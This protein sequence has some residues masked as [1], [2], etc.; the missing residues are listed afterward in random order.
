MAPELRITKFCLERAHQELERKRDT[1]QKLQ[2]A[3]AIRE[4]YPTDFWYGFLAAS[5]AMTGMSVLILRFS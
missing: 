4:A 5:I 1:I 3:A 2:T